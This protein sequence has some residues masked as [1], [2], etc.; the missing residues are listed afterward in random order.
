MAVLT[1]L[2]R[3]HTH[4]MRAYRHTH[5][6]THAHNTTHHKI[7]QI[8]TRTLTH[9]N[10]VIIIIFCIYTLTQTYYTRVVT[11]HCRASD[12]DEVYRVHE[13]K[14]QREQLEEEESNLDH[15]IQMCKHELSLLTENQEN[16]Q[17]P[18]YQFDCDFVNTVI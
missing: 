16:W 1:H 5:T 8:H 7:H 4:G 15:L 2:T 12:P 13:M 14:G 6:H 9:I 17:Y 18:I 11:F 3:V 10:I